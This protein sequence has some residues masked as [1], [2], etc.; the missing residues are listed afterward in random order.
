[1]R[2]SRSSI[3]MCGQHK[4]TDHYCFSS[5]L[6]CTVRAAGPCE[7]RRRRD[8]SRG[9]GGRGE[10]ASWSCETSGRGRERPAASR[11]PCAGRWQ[12][13]ERSPTRGPAAPSRGPKRRPWR[14]RK[15]RPPR[16][17]LPPRR[18]PANVVGA[19]SPPPARPKRQGVGGRPRRVIAH[20][21]G[22][23]SRCCRC[24]ARTQQNF[25]YKIRFGAIASQSSLLFVR[26]P[27]KEGAVHIFFN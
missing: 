3:L 16:P 2:D 7:C 12:W 8:S 5:G 11:P 20:D 19:A 22:R 14:R 17:H 10:D 15:G 27:E 1:M 4:P 18:C 26:P 6:R 25:G 21:W 24:A 23:P 9:F 13:G